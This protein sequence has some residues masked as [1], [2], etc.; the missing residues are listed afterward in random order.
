MTV[1]DIV[2]LLVVLISTVMGLIRGFVRE[3][4]S[5]VFWI[6]GV[7]AAWAFGPR[8]EPYLGGYL[9]APAVRPWVARLIVLI[10]VVVLGALVAI[11]VGW[12]MRSAGLGLVDRMI[13]LM[14][15]ALRGLVLVGLIVIGGELLHLND[16]TWWAR[17]RLIPYGEKLGGLIKAVVGES[18]EPGA[19]HPQLTGVDGN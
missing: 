18:G 17:S 13:G 16:E 8:I 10:A 9:A 14:F 2:I 3:A 5:L 6:A 4:V 15:G 11:L 19:K 7:Y 12:V 1:A